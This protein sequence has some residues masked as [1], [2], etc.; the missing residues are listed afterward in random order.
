MCVALP[1]V[2]FCQ[3]GNGEKCLSK[4]DVKKIKKVLAI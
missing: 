4:K 2:A 3:G 1:S